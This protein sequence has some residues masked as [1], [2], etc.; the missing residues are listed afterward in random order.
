MQVCSRRLDRSPV[1]HELGTPK[2]VHG[3]RAVEDLLGRVATDAARTVT[4]QVTHPVEDPAVAVDPAMV[5]VEG[6]EQVVVHV[7][8]AGGQHVRIARLCHVPQG[9]IGGIGHGV[10]AHEP[11]LT[12]DHRGKEVRDVFVEGSRLRL[13]DQ[14][15]SIRDHAVRELVGNDVQGARE[16]GEH[17]A[18]AV[19]EVEA[20]GRRT[21]EGI[22]HVLS[23][24]DE[25]GDVHAVG[26]E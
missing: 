13:V 1:V 4:E 14:A 15:G 8:R 17:V 19:A 22:V 26:V 2:Q 23:V 10:F 6:K 18:A 20:A 25:S 9:D 5:V 16:P 11:V 3:Q 21:P 7:G 24:M 12:I